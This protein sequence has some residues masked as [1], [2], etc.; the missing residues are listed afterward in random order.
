M[1]LVH[2]ERRV[3]GKTI[4]I[5]DPDR[6]SRDALSSTLRH[7]GHQVIGLTSNPRDG[8]LL[9]ATLAPAL[10]IGDLLA[11]DDGLSWLEVLREAFPETQVLVVSDGDRPSD[12]HRCL[13][14]G[15]ELMC[16]SADPEG[17]L[18]VIGDATERR[19]AGA[20]AAG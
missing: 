9:V 5:I 20:L 14:G 3:P 1:V 10:V 2:E 7:A 4:V 18:R 17:L 19:S 6:G 11:F 15:V 13:R 8:T 16:K 12:R